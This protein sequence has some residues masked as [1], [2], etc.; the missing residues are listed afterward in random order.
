[1]VIWT[2]KHLEALF[3]IIKGMDFEAQE[4]KIQ[5][6]IEQEFISSPNF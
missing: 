5:I 1:M 4:D 3:F 6:I 2:S